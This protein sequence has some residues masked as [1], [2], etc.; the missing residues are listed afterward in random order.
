MQTHAVTPSID[1]DEIRVADIVAFFAETWRTIALAAL[2][3]GLLGL[4]YAYLAPPKYKASVSVQLGKVANAD[5]E[6]PAAVLEKVLVPSFFTPETLTA[7]GVDPVAEGLDSM[8][9]IINPVL[10]RTSSLL[11]FSVRRTSVKEAQNCLDAVLRDIQRG[12]KKVAQDM[13][14]QKQALLANLR[15]K[16]DEAERVL[17]IYPENAKPNKWADE[18]YSGSVVLQS[19][20]MAKQAELSE[21][22]S[23]ISILELALVQPQTSEAAFAT[24]IYAPPVPVGPA[25]LVLV[26]LAML[27][28]AALA[29]A[30]CLVHRALL[31]A[32][33]DASSGSA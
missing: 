24:P 6:A 13:V 15:H 31:R 1:S 19:M 30:I 2:M 32:S 16:A 11:A 4:V 26:A 17:A 18:R 22:R 25:K 23:Q 12:Q 21:L 20:L 27:L 8:A 28:G 9:K 10:S 29:F 5:V 7:C 14:Q 3:A 33:K